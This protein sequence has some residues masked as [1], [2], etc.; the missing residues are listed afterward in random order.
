MGGS[1][2]R[3]IKMFR[4]A[5]GDTAAD[6]VVI[7]TTKWDLVPSEVGNERHDQLAKDPNFFGSI[8]ATGA[9]MMKY[10]KV[11][12]EGVSTTSTSPIKFIEAIVQKPLNVPL[13]LPYELVD[14]HKKINKTAAGRVIMDDMR[15]KQAE[16]KYRYRTL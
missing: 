9:K 7:L 14:K 4:K 6:N 16:N 10:V 5:V 12:A 13:Q 3:N 11:D 2:V 15:K 1:A 8:L